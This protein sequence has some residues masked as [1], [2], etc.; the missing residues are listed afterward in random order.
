MFL[1]GFDEVY[2][3]FLVFPMISS[4]KADQMIP[5]TAPTAAEGPIYEDG[6]L[7]G[8]NLQAELLRGTAEGGSK[9]AGWSQREEM[10]QK[11]SY[12]SSYLYKFEMS[13]RTTT[14]NVSLRQID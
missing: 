1:L 14:K 6:R 12:Y 3:F 2:R 9:M 4:Q 10:G 13:C 8:A 7:R 5:K 11:T